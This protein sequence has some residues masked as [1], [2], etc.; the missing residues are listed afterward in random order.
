MNIHLLRVPFSLCLTRENLPC[1]FPRLAASGG[2]SALTETGHDQFGASSQPEPASSDPP[3]GAQTG[4]REPS[5]PAAAAD[6]REQALKDRLDEGYPE[7]WIPEQPGDTL[8]GIFKRLDTANTSRGQRYI[9]VLGSTRN[10]DFEKA[11]WLHH[12]ALRN[13][14]R[15]AAPVAGEMVAVR[16][17]GKKISESTKQEYDGWTVRVDRPQSAEDVDWSEV[18][19]D[20]STGGEAPLPQAQVPP[21]EPPP[22]VEPHHSDDD[23]PF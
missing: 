22:P 10:L 14:F 7:A 23:I 9:V 16:W 11:I 20:D 3:S 21:P 5:A 1:S 6:A 18:P 4:E 8:V 2:E 19:T 12:T 17:D 13:Q 15:Q